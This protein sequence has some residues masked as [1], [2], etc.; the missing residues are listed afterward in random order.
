MSATDRRRSRPSACVRDSVFPRS[1]RRRSVIRPPTGRRGSGSRSRRPAACAWWD[2]RMQA[3]ASAAA[4]RGRCT[5]SR[6]ITTDR[7][8]WNRCP[9]PN[10]SRR[11][12]SAPRWP[13]TA[14]RWWWVHPVRIRP[15]A[16]Q[17]RWTCS[18][19]G[20]HPNTR[21]RTWRAFGRPCRRQALDSAP[22]WQS[23]GTGSPSANPVPA[24]CRR[25]PAPSTCC[26]AP[27]PDGSSHR[28]C[29]HPRARSAGTEPA[30]RS[31]EA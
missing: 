4:T 1:V 15:S 31:R 22:P 18:T 3:A 13:R 30:S 25:A 26:V 16:T 8:R 20:L 24:H 2:R 28:P 10:P 21:S 27:P 23:M 9:A 17:A 14:R 19:S 29:T 12:S 11:R 5:S 6:P 7:G